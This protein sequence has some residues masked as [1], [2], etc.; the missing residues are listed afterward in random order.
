MLHP[1]LPV[2]P[3][4]IEPQTVIIL[5][6]LPNQSRPQASPLSGIHQALEYGVLNALP[7]I[8]TNLSNS[9]QPPPAL[10]RFRLHVICNH[11][12]HHRAKPSALTSK[13]NWGSRPG[14][15]E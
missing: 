3:Q 14:L 12:K 2:V 5:A 15:P 7:A 4:K 9:S 8:L 1:P 13:E 11:Y 6:D 10:L